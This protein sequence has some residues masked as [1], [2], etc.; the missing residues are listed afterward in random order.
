MKVALPAVGARFNTRLAEEL[1]PLCAEMG[2]TVVGWPGA[3]LSAAGA[4]VNEICWV[5]VGSATEVACTITLPEG[6]VAGGV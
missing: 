2:G 1:P 6:A 3:K 5:L 4:T